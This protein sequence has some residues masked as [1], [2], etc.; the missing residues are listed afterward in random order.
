MSAAIFGIGYPG[1]SV[2]TVGE[3]ANFFIQNIT[4]GVDDLDIPAFAVSADG[5][6]LINF[7]AME[8]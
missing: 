3:Q 5:V 2:F 7:S 1:T 6:S 4:S 8:K